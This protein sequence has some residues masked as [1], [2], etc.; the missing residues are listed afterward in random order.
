[1]L[2][3]AFLIAMRS[4]ARAVSS[5]KKNP[6][7]AQPNI[8]LMPLA[9]GNPNAARLKAMAIMPAVRHRQRSIRNWR[10]GWNVFAA[11]RT[12]RFSMG[13]RRARTARNDRKIMTPR[14][15]GGRV[16]INGQTCPPYIVN[17]TIANK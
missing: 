1:M 4:R 17:T 16:A 14:F 12:N 11:D 13:L 6:A 9:I 15:T 5:D 7:T 10:S 2:V 3:I 8:R